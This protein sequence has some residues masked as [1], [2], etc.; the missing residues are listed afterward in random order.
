MGTSYFVKPAIILKWVNHLQE[1]KIKGELDSRIWITSSDNFASWGGGDSSYHVEDLTAL[2]KAVDYISLHTYP[3]HDTH[4]NPSFWGLLPEEQELNKKEKVEA[5]MLRALDY[6][7]SQYGSVVD[8]I[9]SLGIEKEIHIGESGWAT[10]DN[11]LYGKEGSKAT[12]EYKAKLYH[13]GLRKWTRE[14]GISFFYFEA[15]NEKWKDAIN[16]GGSENHFGLF[17]V[18]GKAKYVLWDKVDKGVFEKLK[19]N[20]NSI[21]KT[22]G[23]SEAELLKD[24]FIPSV[25]NK[26]DNYTY[27]IQRNN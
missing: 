10:T 18:D 9:A 15:F 16:P 11:N 5:L 6:A 26:N 14:A 25:F 2:I 1:L 3:Y 4:Y 24:V 12:D 21:T 8:Y 17:T 7:K 27:I 22:Y 19:R 23:G 13:D 20:G